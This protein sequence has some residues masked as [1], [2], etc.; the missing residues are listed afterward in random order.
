M[1]NIP[2]YRKDL[3]T[4]GSDEFVFDLAN[5]KDVGYV[6]LLVTVFQESGTMESNLALAQQD[7]V[8]DKINVQ[9]KVASDDYAL[10]GTLPL[11]ENIFLWK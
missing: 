11:E 9:F 8:H 3:K 4:A 6:A 1:E 10:S 5:L 2:T 7:F